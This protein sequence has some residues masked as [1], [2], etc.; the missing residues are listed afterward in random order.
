[1]RA[2]GENL[3]AVVRGE[4]TM[5]EPMIQ[6]NMLN[7]FYVIAHGMPR[8]TQYLASMASQIGHRY[9]HMNVLEIGAGTGGATKSFLKEIGDTFSTYT[10]TD[11]SSGFFEKA[12][13]V[14]AA[15]SS[16]M[17]F[18]VLNI[19]KDIEEQGFVDGSYDLIIAS[20]VL[21]AT[22]NL[23]QTMRNVRRLLKPGGYLLLLE[24]TENEQ[25]RFGLIFGGLEGWW[26]GYDDGRALS[27]CVGLDEWSELLKNTGFS[28][29]DVAMPHD[30]TLPVP[31]SII[32]S[33]AVDEK[34]E[35]L[36][37]PLQ[38]SQSSTI[39]P[40]LSVIEGGPTSAKLGKDIMQLLSPVCGDVRFIASPSDIRPDDLPI[41]GTVLC[42]SDVDEPFFKSV[43]AD[44][45]SG[46]QEI[47]KQSENVLWVTRGSRSGDPY[48]RMIVGLGRTLV[49][50]MLHVRL[51]FLDMP[52]GESPDATAIAECLLRLQLLGKWANDGSGDSL[53]HSIEPELYLENGH[54]LVPRFKLNKSQNNRYNSGR[55]AITE[56]VNP[57]ETVIEIVHRERSYHLVESG[58]ASAL[59]ERDT[60]EM[61]VT[62]SVSRAIEVLQDCFLFAVLGINRATGERALALSSTQASVVQIPNAFVLPDIVLGDDDDDA[63]QSFYTELLAQSA[64]KGVVA[65]DEVLAL[66]LDASLAHSLRRI[67]T[68]RGATFNCLSTQA[69]SE[70]TYIHPKASKL[71][72][73]R[74]LPESTTY[75][76]NMNGDDSLSAAIAKVLHPFT[77]IVSGATLTSPKPHSPPHMWP[78]LRSLL[79]DVKY[80]LR[81]GEQTSQSFNLP[82]V[83]LNS[84]NNWPEDQS[85]VLVKWRDSP[86]VSVQVQNIDSK[87]RFRND[88]TY[89][90]VGL[91]GGLGQSL[92][93]WIAHQGGR[94]LA[95]SSRNPKVDERWLEKMRSM[96]VFVKVIAK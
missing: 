55:R 7:D 60:V 73:E 33:Q 84:V 6:D 21:H 40:R 5:L 34:I 87:V 82:I 67:A 1:M 31:L 16:R 51:Q 95:I 66:D 9:P 29:I 80:A 79:V 43:S 96:G 35:F 89:W 22:R 32:V 23:E 19:E 15:Y 28:G 48:S 91:T 93:E 50:E 17:S 49:L 94:Y 90:L 70:W 54:F 2:V 4:L 64:M 92:C 8:Y 10:F 30:K 11:I 62:H 26:L 71:E 78:G 46:L 14:F 3:P 74:L 75:Y 27:P 56:D 77:K 47:F 25:M 42:L 41:G 20:L 85:S 76:F 44:K 63:L 59:R 38:P 24:I 39:I 37:H 18:R 81:D 68:N 12:S 69:N 52:E 58:S 72:I 13:Q 88:K 86:T 53:L 61:E 36:K 57:S 45:L 83:D 65:N